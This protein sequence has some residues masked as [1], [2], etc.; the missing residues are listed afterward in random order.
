MLG[1]FDAL[2]RVALAQAIREEQRE[3]L[4]TMREL[5]HLRFVVMSMRGLPVTFIP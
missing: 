5:T 2:L 1:L 3:R 4:Q